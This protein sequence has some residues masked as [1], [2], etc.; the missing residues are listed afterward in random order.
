MYSVGLRRGEK[1]MLV[2][3][4]KEG[5]EERE[6]TREGAWKDGMFKAVERVGEVDL[7]IRRAGDQFHVVHVGKLEKLGSQYRFREVGV[8]SDSLGREVLK[9]RQG[10]V[11]L[12]GESPVKF[13]YANPA[14][15]RGIAEFYKYLDT[16][17]SSLEKNRVGQELSC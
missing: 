1:I 10:E 6:F 9:Y 16:Y 7:Y 15:D 12:T 3:G 2:Y 11:I 5:E 14:F 4:I 17:T 13:I 8:I